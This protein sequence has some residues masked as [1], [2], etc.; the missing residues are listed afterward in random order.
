MNLAEIVFVA[1]PAERHVVAAVA[2]SPCCSCCC[3]CCC[4]LHAIGGLVGASIG[5]GQGIVKAGDRDKATF[6]VAVYWGVFAFLAVASTIAVAF[7]SE[8]IV[9][10]LYLILLAPAIQLAASGATCLV[11]AVAPLAN[12]RSAF[13]AV[14]WITLWSFVG[15]AI[16]LL[17]MLLAGGL[18]TA[19]FS[20][21]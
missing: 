7:L 14:G 19:V 2:G 3:C 20:S 4:C 18:L 6:G 17:V 16:G 15:S 9:A 8:V 12:K 10:F 13:V 5:S 11:I 21:K 1:H